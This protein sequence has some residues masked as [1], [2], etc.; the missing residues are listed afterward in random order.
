VRQFIFS[1]AAEIA[2]HCPD[3]IRPKIL[4]FTEILQKSINIFPESLDPGSGYLALC[5][6]SVM[7]LSEFCVSFPNDMRPCV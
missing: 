4:D 6:N 2:K 1:L 5:N 3:M 7:C